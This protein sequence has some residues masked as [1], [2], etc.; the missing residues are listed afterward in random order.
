MMLNAPHLACSRRLA[1]PCFGLWESIYRS[2]G[3]RL[4]DWLSGP[5]ILAPSEFLGRTKSLI[6]MPWLKSDGLFGTIL[7]SDGQFDDAR[8][9]LAL[10][11]SC[12]AAGGDVVNYVTVTGFGMDKTDRIAAVHLEDKES[13]K[14]LRVSARSFV[15]ATGP[16]SDELRRL[17][18]PDVTPRLRVSKG[19]H[20]LLPLPHEC[21]DE[22]LLIPAT[23]DGRVV[24][25]IPWMGRLLV[26]TTET[27]GEPNSEML[28]TKVEAEYLLRHLN[29]YLAQPFELSDI[30][31]A[32]AG[33]R[34]LIQ[35]ADLRDSKRIVRDYEIEFDARS[36]LV[37][38]LGG[39]W[40]V[41]RTM[42]EDTINVVEK[43][44]LCR[45]SHC[46]TRAYPLYGAVRRTDELKKEL[47]GFPVP[48]GTIDHLIQKFG[49]R[50]RQVLDLAEQRPLLFEALIDGA[51]YIRAEVIYC[52][53]E[54]L[55][56]SLEDVLVRRLGLEYFDWRMAAKAAPIVA[57]L[58]AEEL[59][60]GKNRADKEVQLYVDRIARRISEIGLER[61]REQV[62]Y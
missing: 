62:R 39:K 36:G 49:S 44:L 31:D 21:G 50:A 22:G 32:I 9:N 45:V 20:I 5:A 7:Y 42:A 13:G 55:A 54:E 51:P 48:P 14:S 17:A 27:E 61:V 33:L 29:P 43:Q 30:V 8:Y 23:E 19:V 25:A 18:R 56:L 34:P 28:V 3:V 40:T 35:P 2:L 26:G 46:D 1:V 11:Q 52:V 16:F 53:R 24:F 4:Y 41:Y 6:R 12:E 60:W 58:M 37:S 47:L 57:G 10:V 59:G 38:V 15:N